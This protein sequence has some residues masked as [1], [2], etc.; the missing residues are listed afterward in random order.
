MTSSRKIKR[1][2]KFDSD[3]DLLKTCPNARTVQ[4]NKEYQ[5]NCQDNDGRT[6]MSSTVRPLKVYLHSFFCS[7]QR[8]MMLFRVTFSRHFVPRQ[9]LQ[10]FFCRVGIKYVASTEN[11]VKVILCK[12]LYTRVYIIKGKLLHRYHYRH[13][14]S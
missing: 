10:T 7:G 12:S 5:V 11:L 2:I 8:S 9:T 1:A 6:H 3:G 14:K 13:F 4:R